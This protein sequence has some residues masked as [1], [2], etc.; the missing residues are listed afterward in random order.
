MKKNVATFLV[1]LSISI[2]YAQHNK[3]GILND[4][5]YMDIKSYRNYKLSV[6]NTI[7]SIGY[8]IDKN[9]TI[10]TVKGYKTKGVKVPYEEKDSIFLE[11]YKDI[12][13]NKK[14]YKKNVKVA[15][16]MKT[17]K[18]EIKIYVDM[19]LNKNI[20]KEF[21]EFTK[22]IDQEVDSLKIS[23]V[24][25]I[26]E[27]NYFIY[28]VTDSMSKN[29]DVRIIN[30]EG[31]YLEWNNKQNINSCSLKVNT[32][33]KLSN[34]QI[35]TSLK[36]NFVRSL[37]YFYAQPDNLDCTS[38]F[39]TCPS[40][41]KIFGKKDLEILKYHYSYGICKGTDLIIFEK[42]HKEAKES[43]KKNNIK[44]EFIH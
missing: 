4:L 30:K 3:T 19:S 35:V 15:P 22:Y 40:Y 1:L 16:T 9:D 43:M 11:R 34:E 20:V 31:F 13:Y 42:N 28:G 32:Q 8:K 23:F 5:V 24:T 25:A 29:L 2:N 6:D 12:V 39:S 44:I 36:V 41:Q 33:D 18:S 14:Y 37:G 10:I 21:K 26:G 17:W 27:S 38:Y 7:D